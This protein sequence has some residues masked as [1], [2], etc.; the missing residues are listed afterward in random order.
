MARWGILFASFWCPWGS[1]GIHLGFL[2]SHL[3]FP[4]LLVGPLEASWN[5]PGLP[6][7]RPLAALTPPQS[8]LEGAIGSLNASPTSQ[9]TILVRFRVHFTSMLH[10]VE[11]ILACL[12][13]PAPLWKH[14][15]KHKLKSQGATFRAHLHPTYSHSITTVTC[16]P[17]W[18]IPMIQIRP[19]A[20]FKLVIIPADSDYSV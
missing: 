20:R 18:S 2:A 9:L 8:P 12:F 4:G 16:N 13:T 7:G 14:I 5:P 11:I 10:S 6:T 17:N 1:F 15:N 3:R 19:Y